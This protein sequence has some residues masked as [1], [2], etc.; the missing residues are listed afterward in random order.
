MLVS[1]WLNAEHRVRIFTVPIGSVRPATVHAYEAIATRLGPVDSEVYRTELLASGDH[2][3]GR[4]F[5]ERA[6]LNEGFI[7]VAQYEI[8]M[9]H[10]DLEFHLSADR[11]VTHVSLQAA[12]PQPKK[13]RPED[14][15]SAFAQALRYFPTGKTKLPRI[16]LFLRP[17]PASRY[18]I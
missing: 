10:P 5:S 7:S 9:G 18:N 2:P 15:F 13:R 12:H 1:S 14:Y 4:Q 8:P 6:W 16:K 11:L 17:A 3:T